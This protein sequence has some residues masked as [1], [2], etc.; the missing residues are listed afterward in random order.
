MPLPV[1]NLL[2]AAQRCGVLVPSIT[3]HTKKEPKTTLKLESIIS[4]LRGTFCCC[5]VHPHFPYDVGVGG[6]L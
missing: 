4:K 3:K 6:E 2:I 1:T 5:E